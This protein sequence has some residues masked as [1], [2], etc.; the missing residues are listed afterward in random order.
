MTGGPNR[1]S[2]TGSGGRADPRWVRVEDYLTPR[3][4]PDDPV[5][6]A[7]VED[8]LAAGLPAI[9][10]S[11]LEGQFLQVLARA[12]GARRVLEIGTLGGYS[13]IWLGRAVGAGGRV[14]S[15]EI[16]DRHA[17]VARRNLERAGLAD[18]CEVVVGPAQDT[19]RD[20]VT[21]GEPP[22]DLV[23]IDADKGRLP[24]YLRRALD[25]SRPGTLVVVDNVVRHG[26][27]AD[28]DSQDTDVRGTQEMLALV[29]SL[30]VLDAPVLQTVGS[31]GYDGM[32][33]GRVRD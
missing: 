33:V 28:V 10:V 9:Q 19:L 8:S 6:R 5:L 2:A 15:L 3:L 7:A 4:V 1:P 30:D 17:R 20:L 11:P 16:S 18:R 23:F 13:T 29:A 25:L 14:V 21:A 24:L 27:V 26:T 32:L 22:Y 12:V 31:K